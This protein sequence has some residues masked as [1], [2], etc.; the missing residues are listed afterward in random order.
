MLPSEKV[1]PPFRA[2]QIMRV[3]HTRCV[4]VLTDMQM[5]S[6]E[7]SLMDLTLSLSHSLSVFFFYWVA[8][9]PAPSHHQ[10][11]LMNDVG[12]SPAS[13]SRGLRYYKNNI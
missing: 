4:S 5:P 13:T 8:L 3:H 11:V 9:S 7:V 1:S 6:W 2:K 10:D 12:A